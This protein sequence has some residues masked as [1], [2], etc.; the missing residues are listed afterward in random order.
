MMT[1]GLQRRQRC[2]I[3]RSIGSSLQSV[4]CSSAERGVSD[5]ADGGV[6]PDLLGEGQILSG[7]KLTDSI[8]LV[9]RMVPEAKN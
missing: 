7:G 1:V 2:S 5:L 8:N 6:N 4:P 9:T 3:C